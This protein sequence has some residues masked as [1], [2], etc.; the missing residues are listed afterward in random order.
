M[1]NGQEHDIEKQL[2]S[3]RLRPAPPG[4]REKVL[5]AAQERK[6]ATAWT[7]PLLRRC[8]AGCAAL[9]A[10]VFIADDA[11][12][13]KQNVRFQAILDGAH[14]TQSDQAKQWNE[15]LEELRDALGPNDLAREKRLLALQ[16]KEPSRNPGEGLWKGLSS[17]DIDGNKNTKDFD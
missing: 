11:A 5:G 2:K 1:K 4:L 16:K 12:T 14:F 3:V 6:E 9:L 8:L 15:E 17:E 7:T 10:V 13:R